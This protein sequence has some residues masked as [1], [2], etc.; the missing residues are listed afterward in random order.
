MF[1]SLS[2]NKKAAICMSGGEP[3]PEPTVLAPEQA[4]ISMPGGETLPESTVAATDLTN[5]LQNWKK[6]NF[7]Y[8]WASLWHLST[9]ANA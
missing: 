1:F 9:A 6:A 2:E 7:F 5:S 3:S 8:L 4:P